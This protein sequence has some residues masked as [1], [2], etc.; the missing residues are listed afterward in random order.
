[1]NAA[2]KSAAHRW[3]AGGLAFYGLALFI[4]SRSPES[5]LGNALAL[6]VIFGLAF[7]FLA[8]LGTRRARLLP[9]TVHPTGA[10]MLTLTAYLIALS[11]YPTQVRLRPL[12]LLK[13]R[14]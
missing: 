4:L 9:S 11:L 1:M 2:P 10:E 13:E 8:W 7:P 3:I 6:F 12:L 14:A 5:S